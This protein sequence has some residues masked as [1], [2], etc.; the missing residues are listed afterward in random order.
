MA[1]KGKSFFTA[2]AISALAAGAYY[3]YKK[4]STEI[5][6]DMDDDEDVDS[7]DEEL[8]EEEIKDETAKDKEKRS[9]VSLDLN[10]ATQKVQDA[11]N[12]VVDVAGKAAVSLGNIIKQGEERVE[13]FFDDRKFSNVNVENSVDDYVEEAADAV[14]EAVENV[15]DAVSEAVDETCDAVEKAE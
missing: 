13:E 10:T 9:Y 7:F 14:S 15:A 5:A 3:L 1:K 2:V 11:A 4:S 12:K 6:V 8:D